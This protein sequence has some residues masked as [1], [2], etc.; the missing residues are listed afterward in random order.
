MNDIE[1]RRNWAR[2][3]VVAGILSTIGMAVAVLTK[4]LAG[5][6]LVI[7]FSSA[8]GGALFASILGRGRGPH[9]RL[10]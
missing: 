9:D 4:S 3:V 5:V 10:S 1:H 7:V 6:V 8:V 2:F